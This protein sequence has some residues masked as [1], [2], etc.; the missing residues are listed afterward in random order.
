MSRVYMHSWMLCCFHSP[1]STQTFRRVLT[2]SMDTCTEIKSTPSAVQPIPAEFGGRCPKSAPRV[3]ILPSIR[4]WLMFS[5]LAQG[6][7]D[8]MH[9]VERGIEKTD[10]TMIGHWTGHG[11]ANRILHWPPVKKKKKKAKKT[12]QNSMILCSAKR[13]WRMKSNLH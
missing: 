8:V 12:S 3:W 4:K 9:K 6:Q 1:I 13:T 11:R 5:G 2:A 10:K 7:T